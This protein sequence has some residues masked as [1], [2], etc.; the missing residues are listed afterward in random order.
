MVAVG[1]VGL[2][3]AV[4][5]GEAAGFPM[6]DWSGAVEVF[7]VLTTFDVLG[8]TDVFGTFGTLSALDTVAPPADCAPKPA[9]ACA[10]APGGR[11]TVRHNTA[12]IKRFGRMANFCYTVA[13]LT[14]AHWLKNAANGMRNLL[15]R[16]IVAA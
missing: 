9:P 7:G 2:A 16:L 5:S 14:T 11:A 4:V 8:A 12:A 10:N 3:S 1:V 13:W 15:E 6:G